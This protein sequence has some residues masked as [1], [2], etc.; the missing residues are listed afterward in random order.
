MSCECYENPFKNP[1]DC[2]HPC[3]IS[4]KYLIEFVISILTNGTNGYD[5]EPLDDAVYFSTKQLEKRQKKCVNLHPN[6]LIVPSKE[7]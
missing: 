6:N 5:D 7:E 3:I 1:L 2:T 4:D